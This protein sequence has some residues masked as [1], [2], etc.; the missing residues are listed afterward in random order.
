[1]TA[2]V[3]VVP[4]EAKS[5]YPELLNALEEAY[6]VRF[7]AQG[8][9]DEARDV[10]AV[11]VLEGGR[12]PERLHVPCLVL[13]SPSQEQR[14]EPF[15]VEMS[16]SAQLDRALVGQTLTE[17]A[18][19]RPAEIEVAPGHD[20]LASV[21]GK[22]VWSCSVPEGGVFCERACVSPRELA[23]RDY[24][25]DHLT[26]GNFW[27]LLPLVQFL[28]RLTSGHARRAGPHTACLVIDDPNVRF[29]SYGYVRF[30]ELG[31]DAREHGYHVSVATIPL[32]LVFP[33]GW[34]L[35]A[36][37]E[38]STELSLVVHGSDHLRRELDRSQAAVEADR[39]IRTAEAR[40]RR[41]EEKSR[42]RIERVMCPPHGR[43]GPAALAA[44]FRW[45]FDGLAAAEPFPW[46]GFTDQRDWRLGGWLPAQ[47]AGGGLPVLPRHPLGASL[48]DLV[49]RA[50]LDQPLVVYCHHTDLR[51][52]VGAFHPVVERVAEL[53]EVRW[54][55]LGLIARTNALVDVGRGVATVEI[56]SRDVCISRPGSDSLRIAIPRIFGGDQATQLAVDG[57]LVDVALDGSG[58][59][60]V[61][62]PDRPGEDEL[63]IR[64]DLPSHPT[65]MRTNGRLPRPWALARRA[66]T[67]GRDRALPRV[68][69][70]RV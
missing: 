7:I 15:A 11:V 31:R 55:S 64:L 6:P 61:D 41:F 17:H 5:R 59:V 56:Y 1:M 58:K 70:R 63:R 66:M 48:D 28:K 19:A 40:V 25:R 47:L 34:G 18:S 50:F 21:A 3:A 23:D 8:G 46:E 42:F 57:S 33:G 51:E 32:D 10:E 36:F 20:V 43:C 29:P 45:N 54:G 52:G 9:K 60:I 68:Y 22:P 44:L 2:T 69:R 16:R 38:Y 67:E 14:R 65:E 30:A 62:V 24:L 49:F 13:E 26:A 27:S 4:G 39:I 12:A 53:G 37:R 35:Q